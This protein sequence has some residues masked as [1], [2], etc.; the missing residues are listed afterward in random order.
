MSSEEK[1]A[2]GLSTPE[3]EAPPAFGVEAEPVP[4][5]EAES[6]FTRNGLNFES[7]KMRDYGSSSIDSLDRSLRSRHMHMIAIGGSIGAGFF[8]GSGGA[9]NTGGPGSL[10]IDFLIIGVMIFNTVQALGEL[11]VMYPVSGGFYTY[12]TRFIDPSWGFAMGWNYVMQ[13][14]VV[15]PLELTVC[16]FTVGYWN[17]EINVAVWITVFLVAIIIINVFG[18]LGYA[19][20]EFWASLLKLGATVVFMFIALVLVCGGGPKGSQYDHYWGARL[21]YE[22]GAFANGFRGFCSVFV[23]AAFA[24]SGTELV[25]LAAA[26]ARNPAKSLPGAIKQ[27]FWRITL[28]Y[29]LGLFFVG[30]LIA[31]D[32]QNLLGA[33]PFINVNASPFVLVGKYANLKGFDSFMNVIILISVLSIGVSAVYGGS[34]TLT[35]L[36]QQGY[37]PKIFSYIDRSGRPLFSVIILLAFGPLAYISLSAS[38]PTVFDWLQALSG[39]AALFTWGSI[40]LAHIRFRRAWQYHG[41]TLD[42]IPFKAVGGVYGSYLGVLLVVLVLV[43]QLFVA[44]C[45]VGGGYNSAEGFFMSYLALPVVIAFWVYGFIWKRTGWLRTEQ[46]DVDTGRREH[47]WAVINEYRE[48][49]AKMPA[50]RRIIHALFI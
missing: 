34:R 46:I 12:S 49:L 30:L 44:I 10:L 32:D 39:L 25:G 7:F 42:E 23:T 35:A 14:A 3:K 11:A 8:V 22:P 28:F 4:T 24:F 6:F 13:W 38:G 43:A 26:E 29:V 18:T 37:A 48:K 5:R 27:V 36:A 45:P 20:E 16:G 40:C 15:L 17:S 1:G 9:L 19:E 41:H 50:W 31:Y 21:W 33:N 2:A 47:D